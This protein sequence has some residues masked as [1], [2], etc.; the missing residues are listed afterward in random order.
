LDEGG[1]GGGTEV[2][3]G[4]ETE[5]PC[6][7]DGTW[8]LDILGMGGGTV[9]LGA[10]GLGKGGGITGGAAEEGLPLGCGRFFSAAVSDDAGC[11]FFGVFCF[12]DEN[13][14]FRVV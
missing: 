5:P 11:L 1:T 3:L 8:G 9:I 10:P 4:G 6:E 2:R 12:M 13:F 14:A 7:G